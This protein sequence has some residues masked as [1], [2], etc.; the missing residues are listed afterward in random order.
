M[1]KS[2]NTA[3]HELQDIKTKLSVAE[4]HLA[5]TNELK[6]QLKEITFEKNRLLTKV[7][8]LTV[9]C[10]LFYDSFFDVFC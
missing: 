7:E 4:H 3:I 2:L 8:Y 1:E 5:S 9:G 10:S 6:A